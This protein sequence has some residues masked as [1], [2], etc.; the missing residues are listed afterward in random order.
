MHS[1]WNLPCTLTEAE[2]KWEQQQQQKKN[3]F[4]EPVLESDWIFSEVTAS[5]LFHLR[6]IFII[7][8]SLKVSHFI[9]PHIFS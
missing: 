2:G 9:E 1:C 7:S 8:N 6:V 3:H 4:V 5:E